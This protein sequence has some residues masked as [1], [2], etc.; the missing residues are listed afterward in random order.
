M[1][2]ASSRWRRV[3]SSLPSIPHYPPNSSMVVLYTQSRNLW[4][5]TAGAVAFSIWW[6]EWDKVQKRSL[7]VW[8]ATWWTQGWLTI[9]TEDMSCQVL[10]CDYLP[11]P[12]VLH[13]TLIVF[14]SVVHLSSVSLPFYARLSWLPYEHLAFLR[15][16]FVSFCDHSLVFWASFSLLFLLSLPD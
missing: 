8:L 11:R 2:V 1:L 14:P 12:T 15:V 16:V 9:S 4:L 10:H 5:Y 13:L 6:I 7:G 3:F